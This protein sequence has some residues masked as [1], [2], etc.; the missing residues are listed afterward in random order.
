MRRMLEVLALERDDALVA[1]RIRALVDGHGEMAVTEQRARIGRARRHRRRHPGGVEAGAGAHLARG[2]VVD[3]QHPHRPVALGLQDE[4]SF[5]FQRRP[6]QHG[7][8][9]G[10]AQELGHGD[11]VVVPRQDGVDGGAEAH[12]AAAQVERLDLERQDGVVGRGGR[13]GAGRNVELGIGHDRVDIRAFGEKLT[14]PPAGIS[15]RGGR[16]AGGRP[17]VNVR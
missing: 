7:Q 14:P 17:G 9:D 16:V 8:H 2:G 10:L 13:R 1:R 4:P 15:G 6:Q 3:D 11:G 12:H 5:E